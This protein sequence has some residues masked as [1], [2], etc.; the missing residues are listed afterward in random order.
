MA[1]AVSSALVGSMIVIVALSNIDS[2][3][4]V[5]TA[6]VA[7]LVAMVRMTRPQRQRRVVLSQ[8]PSA[9]APPAVH[10]PGS[11]ARS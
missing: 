2:V 8:G 7:V 6:L 5:Y 11:A 3:P 10:N 9:A 4:Y 1:G